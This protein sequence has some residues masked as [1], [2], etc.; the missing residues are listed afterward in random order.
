MDNNKYI[1]GN[2]IRSESPLN[3]QAYSYKQVVPT[4]QNITYP[5]SQVHRSTTPYKG[6]HI[7]QRIVREVSSRDINNNNKDI[8]Y[9]NG[10]IVENQPATTV[11]YPN[12]STIRR[13]TDASGKVVTTI[14]PDS[15]IKGSVKS[16]N[17]TS[18]ENNILRDTN[19]QLNQSISTLNK[20][21]TQIR[22]KPPT[23]G[24]MGS[25]QKFSN[26]SEM[27]NIDYDQ[28]RLS[29]INAENQRLKFQLSDKLEQNELL[30]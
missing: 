3:K 19:R 30:K 2:S 18:E 7:E 29:M 8:R 21:L 1:V 17:P 20:E 23:Y 4:N 12:T 11:N 9:S 6:N 5:N 16:N 10:R 27:D 24:N 15:Y 26:D 14:A 28:K 22:N 25:S 13:Y